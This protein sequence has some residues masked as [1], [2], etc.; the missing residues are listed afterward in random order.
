MVGIFR[1]SL[2][3]TDFEI[4]L[5]ISQPGNYQK[6]QISKNM[7]VYLKKKTESTAEGGVACHVV[8]YGYVTTTYHA[9]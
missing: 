1:R 4:I 7:L 2:H 6:P 9:A 3:Q 8:L 5:R